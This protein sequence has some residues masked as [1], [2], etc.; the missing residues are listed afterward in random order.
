MSESERQERFKR[1]A[2]VRVQKVLYELRRLSK[3]SNTSNYVY[4]EQEVRKM[5]R[6]IDD[7]IRICKAAYKKNNKNGRFTF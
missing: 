4:T 7:E 6:A 5:W 3:C 2:S 1:V